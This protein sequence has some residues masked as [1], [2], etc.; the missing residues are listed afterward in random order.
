MPKLSIPNP[1]CRLKISRFKAHPVFSDLA[2]FAITRIPIW[3]RACAKCQSSFKDS[4]MSKKIWIKIDIDPDPQ[5]GCEPIV[6]I[7][8]QQKNLIN[9]FV[10]HFG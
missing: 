1:F 10:C 6:H 8:R 3:L 9:K 7:F 4:K 5:Q 2:D